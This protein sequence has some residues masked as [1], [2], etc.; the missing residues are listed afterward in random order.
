[1]AGASLDEHTRGGGVPTEA[2]P[3]RRPGAFIVL[4]Y[5]GCGLA[6][7]RD[8]RLEQGAQLLIGTTLLTGRDQGVD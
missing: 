3:E 8:E 2:G 5:I 6:E 4:L 7:V 1:M